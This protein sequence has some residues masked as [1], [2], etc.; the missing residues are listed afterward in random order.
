MRMISVRIVRL[1]ILLDLLGYMITKKW[2][3]FDSQ[4]KFKIL[5]RHCLEFSWFDEGIFLKNHI[6]VSKSLF[7]LHS[8]YFKQFNHLSL[9]LR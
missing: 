9:Q 6:A 3:F 8:C 5:R 1:V 7:K 2:S 4:I